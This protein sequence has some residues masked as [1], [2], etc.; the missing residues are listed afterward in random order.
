V[1]IGEVSAVTDT[2]A[3]FNA[4]DNTGIAVQ[5]VTLKIRR[6]LKGDPGTMTVRAGVS[7]LDG[8]PILSSSGERLATIQG[9]ARPLL[10]M[11]RAAPDGWV[12]CD[13]PD[14]AGAGL[15]LIAPDETAIV[16]RD[17]RRI[18]AH[19]SVDSL[20]A[21]ADLVLV[22]RL[23]AIQPCAAG[24]GLRCANIIISKTL[25]GNPAASTVLVYAPLI[26]DVPQGE[27]LYVLRESAG[28]WEPLGYQAGIQ[29]IRE[30]RAHLW[31]LSPSAIQ[32]R[33][34]TL[35]RHGRR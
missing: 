13:G 14:P 32:E 8:N 34:A 33:L 12:L 35:G 2:I 28:H 18:L 5:F 21:Q 11:L 19:Q 26:A 23:S 7:P 30:G 24:S 10:L 15:R 17:V 20:L 25:A 1:G 29:S 6:W 16:E 31:M 22:G 27:A 4:V 9:T 3:D